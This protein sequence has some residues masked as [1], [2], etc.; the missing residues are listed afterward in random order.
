MPWSPPSK[1]DS[2]AIITSE[3]SRE[4][5]C[6]LRLER[7]TR[8]GHFRDAQSLEQSFSERAKQGCLPWASWPSGTEAA[9]VQ[10][11]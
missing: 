3:V 1:R 2:L 10:T 8:A 4:G 5:R 6:I 9:E 7:T 11:L